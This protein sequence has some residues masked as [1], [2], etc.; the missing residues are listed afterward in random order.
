MELVR[1]DIVNFFGHE[2]R[3]GWEHGDGRNRLR[4]KAQGDSHGG[5]REWDDGL[6]GGGGEPAYRRKA[7]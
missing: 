4:G 7:A 1:A 3:C 2:E 6:R 5:R